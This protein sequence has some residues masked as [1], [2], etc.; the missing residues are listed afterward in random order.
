ML[1][2]HS[3]INGSNQLQ[4]ILERSWHLKKK[5]KCASSYL[6]STASLPPLILIHPRTFRLARHGS[7]L[8]SKVKSRW[9]KWKLNEWTEALSS[10]RSCP[11]CCPWWPEEE[12]ERSLN[13]WAYGKE[14]GGVG[15]AV[16]EVLEKAMQCRPRPW[17][18]DWVLQRQMHKLPSPQKP[19]PRGLEAELIL[20]L[21]KFNLKKL[22]CVYCVCLCLHYTTCMQMPAKVRR[23]VWSLGIGV[24]GGY[25]S[26]DVGTGNPMQ[27][28]LTT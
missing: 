26:A 19:G 21:I 2:N 6:D 17:S 14:G 20:K 18:C 15:I 16:R 10:V 25:D 11:L 9:T 27:V 12:A 1:W 13:C 28:L 22:F 3:K 7:F 5:T 8:Q 24:A 4:A 23:G